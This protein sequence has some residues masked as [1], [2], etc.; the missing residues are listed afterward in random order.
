MF[1]LRCRMP[2][3]QVAVLEQVAILCMQDSELSRLY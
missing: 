2:V 3:V 1:L